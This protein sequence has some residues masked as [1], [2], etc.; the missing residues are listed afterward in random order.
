MTGSM[1]VSALPATL[2]IRCCPSLDFSS[3]LG[4]LNQARTEP[5]YP[6]ELLAGFP[7]GDDVKSP[8]RGTKGSQFL[9]TQPWDGIMY[10]PSPYTESSILGDSPGTDFSPLQES[11]LWKKLGLSLSWLPVQGKV[12]SLLQHPN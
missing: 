9:G 8:S 7:A 3:G 6:A 1:A 5:L 2:L 12:V 11:L 10:V 4:E